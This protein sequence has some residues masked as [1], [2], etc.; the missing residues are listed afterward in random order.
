MIDATSQE[1]GYLGSIASMLAYLIVKDIEKIEDQ[2]K[3]L[4][5]FEMSDA[6]R[7]AACG[8]KARAISDARIRMKKSKKLKKKTKEM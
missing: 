6:Q 2:V 4:D 7:A 8:V 1:E 3:L 5:Q